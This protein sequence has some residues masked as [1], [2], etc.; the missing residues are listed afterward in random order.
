MIENSKVGDW[1]FCDFELMQIKEMRDE[2]ITDVTDGFVTHGGRDFN[3][4]CF[5]LTMCIKIISEEFKTW[6]DEIRKLGNHINM[7]SVDALL[8]DWWIECCYAEKFD[9]VEQR[10]EFIGKWFI[11]LKNLYDE[12]QSESNKMQNIEIHG[13]KLFK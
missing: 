3:N 4:R 5:P 10:N 2:R 8:I 6:R 11:N 13:F 7:N 1:M 9:I 12:I